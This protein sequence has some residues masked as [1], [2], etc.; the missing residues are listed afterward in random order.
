M[1]VMGCCK[2]GINNLLNG[3]RARQTVGCLH[4]LQL[5]NSHT[6]TKMPFVGENGKTKCTVTALVQNAL[7]CLIPLSPNITTSAS[8]PETPPTNSI[9]QMKTTRIIKAM[10]DHTIT[11][12]I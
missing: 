3:G 4:F 8:K 10:A 2:T 7:S 9:P 5:T 6:S 12:G 11:I 1:R